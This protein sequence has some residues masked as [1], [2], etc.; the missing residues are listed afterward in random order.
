MRSFYTQKSFSPPNVA[1]SVGCLSMPSVRRML[2]AF[3]L[4]LMAVFLPREAFAGMHFNEAGNGSV[5]H[6]P[7]MAE[8]RI[9]IEYCFYDETSWDG[10]FL[11]TQTVSGSDG[12][13]VWVDGNYVCSPD[14]ELS[15]PAGDGNAG[16]LHDERPNNSWWGNTYT[17]TVND[18]T[19]TIRF[20][21]PRWNSNK[22]YVTM[23]VYMDKMQVGAKHTVKVGGTWRINETSTQYEE[24]VFTSNA[25][26]D[27]FSG[28][29][30]YNRTNKSCSV[31]NGALN[32]SYGPTTVAL[33]TNTQY[34]NN[35]KYVEPSTLSVYK[36]Y[37]KGSSN[38]K[39]ITPIKCGNTADEYIC[40]QK[41]IS[42][43]PSDRP[44]TIVYGWTKD[45]L[46]DFL[47]AS[48]LTVTTDVWNKQAKLS[49]ETTGVYGDG[50]WSIYCVSKK[51][52]EEELVASNIASSKRSYTVDVEKYDE[53]YVYALYFIPSGM[54]N[55]DTRLKKEVSV[56]IDGDFNMTMDSVVSGR[57][58]ITVK[59]NTQ[60]YKGTESC[61]FELLRA[62]SKNGTPSGEW[63][64]VTTIPVDE[65]K[66]KYEYTDADK[67]L[68]TCASYI[69]K[70]RLKIFEKD[71]Y[72]ETMDGKLT[73]TAQMT[74]VSATKG[75]YS[76]MVKVSWT[77]DQVSSDVTRFEVS[78]RVKGTEAWGLLYKTSGT[79]NAYEYEDKTALPSLYYDYKVACITTCESTETRTE[80]SDD[81]F[82][83]STGVVSGRI[84]YGTG[85]AVK[86]ARVALVP[87]EGASNQFY[88]LRVPGTG[89]GVFLDGDSA[90]FSGYF[91][92]RAYTLQ[93]LVR[94]DGLQ[95]CKNPV[96]FNLGALALQMDTTNAS[97]KGGF[98]LVL[99]NN[100][101]DQFYNTAIYLKPDVYT[102]VTVSISASGSPTITTIDAQDSVTVETNTSSFSGGLSFSSKETF[103]LC[104]G[105]SY[106]SS[107]DNAFMGYID[108]MRVFSKAL[109][110]D[111]I[112]ENYN[113]T[114]CGTESNLIAYYPVDEGIDGQTTAYDYS[115]TSGVS[116]SN[117]ARIGA[118]TTVTSI[119]PTNHQFGL[120]GLSDS[121][122]NYVIRGVP[123]SGEGTNYMVVPSLGIHEF[124]P[125][126]LTR[127]IGASSLVHSGVDFTDV[128]A[129]PVSGNVYY[130]GTNYP[131]E[132]CSFYVDG[133]I[134]SRDGEIIQSDEN[135]SF[136][137]S[138]PIGDHFI[139][140]KKEGHEF[141]MNGRY[142]D[143]PS[144]VG[145]KHTFDR[146]KK[147]LVFYDTTL[148]NFTGRVVGGSIEGDK[149][150]GFGASTNN[151]GVVQFDLTPLDDRYKLNVIKKESGTAYDYVSNTDSVV[152]PSATYNINSR[153]WRGAGE[154]CKK[155]FVRTDSLTGEFSVLL[156][157]LQYR[158]DNIKVVA[159]D[160]NKTQLKV[161]DA[162]I[163]DASSPQLE[164]TDS[165]EVDGVMQKYNYCCIMKK[166][167][168]SVPSFSVTQR[169]SKGGAFGIS[170]YE[171]EDA[172]GKIAINDIYSFNADS[173]SVTYK[174]GG[175]VF[176]SEE[177]YTFDFEGY[178]EYVNNDVKGKPVKSRVPLAGSVVTISNAL[179]SS[180]SVYVTDT[181]GVAAGSVSNLQ[182]NQLKLD[183]LGKAAYK[184]KAGLPNITAPY[185]RTISINYEVDDR[186]YDWE[187]NGMA[188]VI[189][190]SLPTGNNFVTSGPDLVEMILRDPPGSASSTSWTSGTAHIEAKSNGGTWV[191]NNQ[192]TMT[193]KLGVETSIVTGLGVAVMSTVESVNDL[194][195]G[196]NATVEGE[197]AS[198]WSKSITTTRTV[199]TSAEPEFV[200][201]D[202]DVF[203]GS[204][205]NI[206]FGK[207]R[208]VGFHR[209]GA[210]ES[211][212]LDLQDVVTTGLS[213]GTM[214][215]YTAYYI[216][217]TLIPNLKALRNNLLTTVKDVKGFE[218]KTDHAMYITTLTPDDKEYGSSNHDKTVWGSAATQNVSCEGPSYTMV[219]P[220]DTK[221]YEDSVQWCNTQIQ[222]WEKQLE[223]NEKAKV[224]AYEAKDSKITKNFSFD[225]G[226][227]I[228]MTSE[229][230]ES[231]GSTVENTVTACAIINNSLGFAY[232]KLGM[233][234]DVVLTEGGG[235][236]YNK[237]QSTTELTSFSYTL[238]ETGDDDAISVDVYE[239]DAFSPIFRTRGGQTSDPYEGQTV[240]E[241]YRPGTTIMEATMQ[242][243]KPQITVDVPV[244]TNVPTGSAANF[245]LRLT[246]DSETDEDVYYKL[247]MID[248]TNSNG[249]AI[250][251]DGAVLTESRI[252]KIPAGETI[253]KSMQLWQ[254]NTSVLDYENIG[255]VLAS[256]TQ[257]DPTSTWEQ[258]ADTVYVSAQFVP[259]SSS[260][261]MELDY[262][263]L[264]TQTGDNLNISFSQFDRTYKN[265]KA[266]RIQYR[267][268]GD[269]GW[270][271][272]QEYV[273]N[274]E[275]TVTNKNCMLLPSTAVVT[276][277]L[278]MHNF[279]DGNYT[280]RVLSASTYGNDEVYNT[281]EEID[282][283]KDMQR[284]QPL[285]TPTPANGILSAGD[286]ISIEFN[287][288]ILK[289][290]IT[291]TGNFVVT[292]VL[293][294]AEVS[295]ASALAMTGAE[296]TAATEADINL[297]GKSFSIDA[298]VNMSSAGTLLTHGKGNA[299]FIVSV[300]DNHKLNIEIDGTTYTSK[301]EV[302]MDKWSYLAISYA[303]S[304]DKNILNATIAEAANT[305]NLI[306]EQ[307]VVAYD[308]NGPIAIGQSMKGAIHELT[309]WDEA[310]DMT[311]AILN[312]SK[313]KNPATRHLIG[314]WKMDEGEGTTITD[315]ARNR[316]ITLANESWYLNNENKAVALDGKSHLDIPT[317]DVSPLGADNCAIELWMRADKQNG[318]T[319][320]LQAGDVQLWMTS[321][322]MLQ[323]TSGG[324]TYSASAA[325][326]QDMSW[327][328]VALNILRD[329]NAAVYVDGERTLATNAANIGLT[330]SDKLIVGARRSV[331]ELGSYQ[332]DRQLVGWVDEIRL[333]NATLSADILK[334]RSA[335][336]LAG[337]EDGLVAY[338]PFEVKKLDAHSQVITT[339]SDDDVM[340]KDSKATY[341]DTLTYSDEAPALTEK[342]TE[343]NVDFSY[344]ASD[345]KIFITINEDP[346]TINACR[347]YF[348]VR[349]LSDVNGNPSLPVCWS[350]YVNNNALA[351]NE[352]SMKVSK[353]VG[354]GYTFEASFA[355]LGG[356]QQMWTI[357]G[358]PSWLSASADYGTVEPLAN[359]TITFS[360]SEATA[361][362]KYEETIYLA[363]N[364]GIEVPFTLTLIVE[365]DKP[366]W[367]V[368]KHRFEKWMT[369]IGTLSILG[370][371]SYDEDDIVAAFIDGECRGVAQPTYIAR[372]D[373]S[374]LMFDIYGD[375]EDTGKD[376]T[377]KVYDA[378]TGILHAVTTTSQKVTFSANTLVGKYP[379]PL[380][381]DA[382]NKIEQTTTLSAG[383]NWVSFY[384]K[385]DEMGVRDVFSGVSDVVETV[386]AKDEFAG[387][388]DGTWYGKTF[389]IDNKSMYNVWMSESKAV[390]VIGDYA[391][392]DDRTISVVPGWNWIAYNSTQT[393]S[394]ADALA[395]MDPQDGDLIK[396]QTG[397]AVFD[398]YEWIGSLKA[399]VPGQGYMLQSVSSTK[400]SFNYPTS[401][402]AYITDQTTSLKSA[403]LRSATVAEEDGSFEP[404]DHHKYPGNM[405]ITARVT[406]DGNT[407]QDVEV[408]VLV[409]D[410]C[411][412]AEYTDE[413]GYAYF[414]VPGDSKCTLKFA[415]VKGGQTWT[416]DLS[417]DFAEDAICGSYKVPF[418]LMF[419]EIPET[420]DSQKIETSW[421]TLTGVQLGGK[422]SAKGVYLL[423]T[424]N[425][426]SGDVDVEKVIV[427]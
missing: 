315:Y 253:T 103:G 314:Y 90:K 139:Q 13:A 54:T 197:A 407:Q 287:E 239:Y 357:S 232:N 170:A 150:V 209:V 216:K 158:V 43:E 318:E 295:H 77:V 3:F 214:F 171:I 217:N 220:D 110:K 38:Y 377:F 82:S 48:N 404:I 280:F 84:S 119:V 297:A 35:G 394:V 99:K 247:L 423:R 211:V 134:C 310:H 266:F 178:E 288:N 251:I 262:T 16:D 80:R 309:L 270:T 1:E 218:N 283:V 254:T 261:T 365:G 92:G 335:I 114:L 59:W 325:S 424:H 416:S 389:D 241:Y 341:A 165:M 265:L 168:H 156:P 33:T 200:G 196:V 31:E 346:A 201:A 41:S 271:P 104:F 172:L 23:V 76:G 272:I 125:T 267:K 281:S 226:T 229:T 323:L 305:T 142:P 27:L 116:N 145:K 138:V 81:G 78:R 405:T 204:A 15:W 180:Q 331:S 131:V 107:I 360:V 69:Y 222:N 230:E 58:A 10:Y 401:T 195:V 193:F 355:N 108:E 419:G 159:L 117:H 330:A 408:G 176:E 250:F 166:T 112:L 29:R 37:S 384:I 36:T 351:W 426:E 321:T 381:I 190:G 223:Q 379:S 337:T 258:I 285:G 392:K 147:N 2:C 4:L 400:K 342:R 146:E 12:P 130:S 417:L 45:K 289:G 174:Y 278:P 21:D 359:E 202:A 63:K 140:V 396:G 256:Q 349:E 182:S 71:V 44:K 336:R 151:I 194:T 5:I 264:N 162:Q 86:G 133:E 395:G 311:V 312:K 175:A 414:T 6:H 298:W 409:D 57:S 219:V 313:T 213:Y 47:H 402:L 317:G 370:T 378:S 286:D 34:Y 20:Y 240:T 167:Y 393:S 390:S 109:T 350:A 301:A 18:V 183:S 186:Q 97:K 181:A 55:T 344:T 199:S 277:K 121:E 276:Y 366:N 120:F 198:T 406:L 206:I 136:T 385:G 397:F 208:N 328:H 179:S 22:F 363:D 173:S 236:H 391:S 56:R 94:P 356:T 299:K 338:Y 382:G 388:D 9:E 70:L 235:H 300:D 322:G 316:H 422:P 101:L 95:T 273:V 215:N 177:N 248:E 221:S 319:E 348:T 93:M 332:Y 113:H 28:T 14:W 376:V 354:E 128:S 49:W 263:T 185:S 358:L 412:T 374:F 61:S 164:L 60:Q 302:P 160:A 334:S 100:S 126:Y 163:I 249:A 418:E 340:R 294:G 46:G 347:L 339:G 8:P 141:T 26:P 224:M 269:T 345:N 89:S 427:K 73:G 154:Q 242:I 79:S 96:L 118:G 327:H 189:L 410:E 68:S 234:W 231:K 64:T 303:A 284:P 19:Y 324:G 152:C 333:W 40:T 143:D 268:Q 42:V 260:V 39:D 364:N 227:S 399:L 368:D 111:E 306:T 383:W 246:N 279:S 122:G 148:V 187:Y 413:N 67:N 212:E 257:Y 32:T 50:T 192:T 403:S 91:S 326:L 290:E 98:R 203:I 243:E 425:V 66:T 361:V 87:S 137:I 343:T 74:S 238:A 123:F 72:S 387:C 352:S 85:T 7:T 129:F 153:S 191:S 115:K 296:N 292:G 169:D 30:E 421:Y 274:A 75:D 11:H 367:T 51:S 380:L 275:D 144:N 252:I 127:F 293:N 105:G 373:N 307:P 188:G 155:I 245:T 411:R 17:K 207:A 88:A 62:V 53:D 83:R 237:E 353:K 282:L 259:S 362:G 415:M 291:K 244:I 184:W 65:K 25:M 161:G 398:G 386:K 320:L 135:G 210:T 228:E 124:S 132:G 371:P 372:Y 420:D 233:Q 375:D 149:P 225:A 106:N 52:G 369:S 24:R 157:P 308:G 102:S 255:I 205:T 329:G 304:D